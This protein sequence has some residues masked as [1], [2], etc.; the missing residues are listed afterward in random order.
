MLFCEFWQSALLRGEARE[1]MPGVGFTSGTTFAV[2]SAQSLALC[3][4]CDAARLQGLHGLK[5][6]QYHEKHAALVYARISLCYYHLI[7]L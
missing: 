7:Y 2:S 3:G 6:S 4:D 1:Q 5:Q